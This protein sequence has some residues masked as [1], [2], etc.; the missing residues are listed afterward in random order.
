MFPA[1]ILVLSWFQFSWSVLVGAMVIVLANMFLLWEKGKFQFN[2]WVWLKLL[3]CVAFAA[4]VLMQMRAAADFNI[5]FFAFLSLIIPAILLLAFRQTTPKAVINEVRQS[6]KWWL[7][8]ICGVALGLEVFLFAGINA[9]TFFSRNDYGAQANAMFA[10][11]VL[12]N[13]VFAYIFLKERKNLVKKSI[14]A[15]VI[16]ACLVIIALKPF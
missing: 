15:A 9:S 6:K 4:A 7:I 16:V 14:A 11:Y 1:A 3:G 10:A 8:V 5:A 13:V 2:K 12:L